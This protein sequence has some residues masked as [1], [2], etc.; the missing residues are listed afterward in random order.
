[1]SQ[2]WKEAKEMLYPAVRWEAETDADTAEKTVYLGEAVQG[3]YIDK[4]DGLGANNSTIY[5][6]EVPNVG[7]V[8]VWGSQ[9]LDARMKQI[10]I[11]SEVRI[12]FLG[13]QK[14]K[15]A[16]RKPWRN[17]RVEFAKPVTQ[18]VEA[19]PAQAAAAP[20]GATTVAAS[21]Y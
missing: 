3:L 21:D 20:A 9:V 19:T 13:L 12:T 6:I 11:G 10:V 16:G 14:A 1:M 17:F 2:E 7:K 5:T 8:G 15:V 4:K 18:M